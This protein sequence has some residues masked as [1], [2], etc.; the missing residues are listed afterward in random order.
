MIILDDTDGDGFGDEVIDPSKNSGRA[1]A[2]VTP[3]VDDE[4]KE[5]QFSV[6]NLRIYRLQNKNCYEWNK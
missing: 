2:F 6:D 3:S 5:Y 4:F 1:D